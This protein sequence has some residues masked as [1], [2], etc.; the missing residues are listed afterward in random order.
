MKKVHQMW[1]HLQDLY[2]GAT[3]IDDGK[4]IKKDDSIEEVEHKE[5]VTREGAKH[6]DDMVVTEDCSTSSESSSDADDRCTTSSLQIDDG[7]SCHKQ[8]V[9]TS[10]STSSHCLMRKH[11]KASCDVDVVGHIDSYDELVD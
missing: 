11:N 5:E 8:D 2:G 3:L 1:V 4:I 6:I 7:R 10:H 9:S